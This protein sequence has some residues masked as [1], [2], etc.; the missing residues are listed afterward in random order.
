[1]NLEV[2]IGTKLRFNLLI[3][4]GNKSSQVCL[5]PRGIKVLI[6]IFE[7]N[8]RKSITHLTIFTGIT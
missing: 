7:K 6:K 4:G 1:M 2:L 8:Y 5:L 3:P